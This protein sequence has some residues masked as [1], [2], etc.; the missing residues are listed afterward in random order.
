MS[1]G[2]RGLKLKDSLHPSRRDL[3]LPLQDESRE[4]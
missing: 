4:G 1:F 3:R 2:Y